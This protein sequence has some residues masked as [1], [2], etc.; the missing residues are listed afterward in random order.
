MCPSA[1]LL[2]MGFSRTG[3]LLFSTCSQPLEKAQVSLDWG[4][5]RKVGVQ[6]DLALSPTP[7]TIGRSSQRPQKMAGEL[8][9]LL[10]QSSGLPRAPQPAGSSL[11]GPLQV[12]KGPGKVGLGHCGHWKGRVSSLCLSASSPAGPALPAPSSMP[13]ADLA[14]RCAAPR[15]PALGTPFLQPPHS[16]HKRY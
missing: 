9:R 14:V 1:A 12:G 3:T 15:G 2:L 7:S 8:D 5:V 10:P 13:Q 16:S 6:P 4:G 11:P